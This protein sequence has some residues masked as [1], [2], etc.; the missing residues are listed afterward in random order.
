MLGFVR[1]QQGDQPEADLVVDLVVGLQVFIHKVVFV[2]VLT[3]LGRIPATFILT[4]VITFLRLIQF[5]FLLDFLDP[6]KQV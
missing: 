6:R 2:T 5:A 1:F 3:F 4:P